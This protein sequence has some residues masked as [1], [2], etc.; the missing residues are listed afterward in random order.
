MN[1]SGMKCFLLMMH[2]LILFSCD[3][4]KPA[5]V[6]Q[7]KKMEAAKPVW[8]P[9]YY[10]ESDVPEDDSSITTAGMGK[11]ML[12]QKSD[13]IDIFYDSVLSFSQNIDYL[14]WPAKKIAIGKNEW[15][16]ASTANSVGRINMISTNSKRL[17][18]K[19][20]NHAGM[21]VSELRRD[22]LGIDQEEK[23]FIIYPE[24]I[25]FRIDAEYEKSFFRTRK[26]NIR[27]LNPKAV[28]REI[29]IRCGDC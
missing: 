21:I 20:G 10:G 13:S 4:K 23:A 24:R 6:Q 28:A 7:V 8:Q 27:N 1:M 18:S 12:G 3:E 22:S 29:F 26:P 16:I 25:E 19:S 9:K 11:V 14:E 5:P 15:I 2:I 17:H